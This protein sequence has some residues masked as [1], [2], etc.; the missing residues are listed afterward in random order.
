MEVDFSNKVVLVTGGTR[1]IGKAIAELFLEN[2]AEVIATGTDLKNVDV[3]DNDSVKNKINYKSLDFSSHSSTSSFLK[4]LEDGPPIDILINNAG[5]NKIDDISN[6]NSKD[7]DKV[8]EINLRGPF[9]LTK[10]IVKKMKLL[11]QGHIINIAS[12]F[13]VV[14]KKK[15]S[16][17]STTK[18]GLIGFTK[19]IALDLAPYNIIVN[20]VSPGFVDTELTRKILTVREIEKIKKTIPLLRLAEADEIAKTIIFLCSKYNTYISGQ[21]IIVD[22]GFTIA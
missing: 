1:G 11:K 13:G 4:K 22:G 2:N 14:S 8:N 20:S 16:V 12:I 19:S 21:N 17:Y 9:I 5:I 7:W 10:E 6:I 15:R 18:S 3:S